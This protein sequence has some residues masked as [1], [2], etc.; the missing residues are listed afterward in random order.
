MLRFGVKYL[1]SSYCLCF[2]LIVSAECLFTTTTGVTVDG[3]YPRFAELSD[4][5][6]L[7]SADRYIVNEQGQGGQAI[8]IFR[9][10]KNLL[11]WE[12]VVIAAYNPPANFS[13]AYL[14]V[15]KA[16][17]SRPETILL[18]LRA[19]EG[20]NSHIDVIQST[21]KGKTWQFRSQAFGENMGN[22]TNGESDDGSTVSDVGVYEPSLWVSHDGY[23]ASGNETLF[24][25]YASEVS[26]TAD[27]AYENEQVILLQRS[28]DLGLSWSAPVVVTENEPYQRFG[29]PAII[30]VDNLMAVFYEQ[31][32]L[33][34]ERVYSWWDFKT[35]PAWKWSIR[36]ALSVDGGHSWNSGYMMF[37]SR[38]GYVDNE[39]KS[40]NYSG[41]PV[42]RFL[43][44]PNS[45]VDT[46]GLIFQVANIPTYADRNTAKVSPYYIG[47]TKEGIE[48][49]RG[50][51]PEPLSAW[52][53]SSFQHSISG[54]I[55]LAGDKEGCMQAGFY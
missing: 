50:P 33:T 32:D 5:S 26:A 1:I 53:A 8:V 34:P 37:D 24:I 9:G 7:M 40:I 2:S 52:W 22:L 54:K 44:F 3:H 20:I 29:M 28:D 15:L 19:W 30:A 23:N 49:Y 12:E 13:N 38:L 17:G 55:I 11:V 6:V 4:G 46:I 43:R 51:L 31:V 21:D 35:R 10:D 25:T 16:K 39:G 41:A 18:A 27:H 48:F 36:S 42:V 14:T 47:L 45:S